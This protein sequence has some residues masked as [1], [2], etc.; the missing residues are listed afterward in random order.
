[1]INAGDTDYL[2]YYLEDSNYFIFNTATGVNANLY[3]SEYHIET[4]HSIFP[5]KDTTDDQG[6]LTTSSANIQTYSVTSNNQY[7]K[8]YLRKGSQ[9]IDITRQFAKVDETLAF[10]GGLLGFLLLILTF[11]NVYNKFSYEI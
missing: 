5:W 9:K 8:L 10:I 3:F 11:V 1:M 2:N 6:A 4:D 7:A